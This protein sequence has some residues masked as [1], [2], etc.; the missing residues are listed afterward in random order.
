MEIIQDLLKNANKKYETADHLAYVTYPLIQE[1][2]LIIT[3]ADHLYSALNYL[4]E[5]LIRYERL[6]KRIP[7][8]QE[9]F[10]SKFDLFKRCLSRYNIDR[11]NTLLIYDLK[12]LLDSRQKSPIEFIKKDKLV[13]CS[14]NYKIQTITLSKV[15]EYLSSSKPLFEKINKIILKNDS[16]IG[17]SQRRT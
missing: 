7:P 10:E 4:I 11:E 1:P 12:A 5:A 3:I 2:K 16:R 14:Q 9:S 17:Y 15:K 13:I 8:V 6:Y